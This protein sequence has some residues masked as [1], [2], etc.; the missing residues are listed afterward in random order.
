MDAGESG[1]SAH[2]LRAELNVV[3]KTMRIPRRMKFFRKGSPLLNA[4]APHAFDLLRTRHERPRSC[5]AEQRDEL[6]A[7]QLIE[8]HSIPAS[9]G[10]HA[11][12]SITRWP[13]LGRDDGRRELAAGPWPRKV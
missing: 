8:L 7:F 12:Y 4:D 9:Q 13:E 5:G 2:G 10:L 6:A 11:G 3:K 1:G